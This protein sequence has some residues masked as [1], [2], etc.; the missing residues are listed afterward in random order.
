VI[1]KGQKTT[2]DGG[3]G[4]D[5]ALDGV[6]EGERDTALY[7]YAC[8]LVGQGMSK[9]EAT[10]L[11]KEAAS[12]CN[13]PF[14]EKEAL[15]KIESAF[16]HE[17]EAPQ[18]ISART[19]AEHDFPELRFA[20]PDLMP[21]GLTLLAGK[22][23][24]GKSWLVLQF[25]YSVA[26]GKNL[27]DRSKIERGG[28]LVLALEDGQRRL[29]T[30]IRKLNAADCVVKVIKEEGGI[31]IRG[32]LGGEIPEGLDLAVS[33]P[34][35]GSG[36]IEQ[37]E[38]YLDEHPDTRLVVIDI[39]K[40]MIKRKGKGAAYDEDYDS[41][42]P[43]QQLATKRRIAILGVYHVRKA[44]SDDPMEM[45]S[46]TFGLTGGADSILVLRGEGGTEF[47]LSV[48]GR[49]IEAKELAISICPVCFTLCTYFKI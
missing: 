23:K 21:E 18:V 20:I 24:V 25:A 4:A 40:R 44:L 49:D 38:R 16:K 27:L 35:I 3:R 17:R 46:G 5:R 1:E 36:G 28:A 30:R 9:P 8:R 31:F 32:D 34:R 14:P 45:V 10:V 42:E 19:L 2:S 29:Q 12:K 41:V 15:A 48:S 11:I 26:L 33:W 39:I 47:R 6:P 43:L 7:K 37:L 22:P 13:P